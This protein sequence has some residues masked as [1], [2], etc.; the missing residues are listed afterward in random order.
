MKTKTTVFNHL[1]IPR[2]TLLPAVLSGVLAVVL[3]SCVERD[4]MG[5]VIK[6]GKNM[7]RAAELDETKA[8]EAQLQAKIKNL[9]ADIA[10]K[11][12]QGVRTKGMVTMGKAGFTGDASVNEGADILNYKLLQQE[13]KE[14]TRAR[15]RLE[16][17]QTHEA[18]LN[19][20]IYEENV[21]DVVSDVSRGEIAS[22]VR[23]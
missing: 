8:E 17:V 23:P 20:Q 21:R 1:I 5:S 7:E 14:L 4:P 6:V 3:C 12:A 10:K 16:K 18:K 15:A 19:K 9:E 11:E 22:T 2:R 13:D